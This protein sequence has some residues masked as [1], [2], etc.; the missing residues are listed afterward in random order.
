MIVR[1]P[2]ERRQSPKRSEGEAQP[3]VPIRRQVLP[4]RY[5]NVRSPRE[6]NAFFVTSLMV[7]FGNVP[8]LDTC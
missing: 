6:G 2:C 3:G 4:F 5:F 8:D 7:P 1:S